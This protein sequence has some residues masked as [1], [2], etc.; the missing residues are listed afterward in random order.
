MSLLLLFPSSGGPAT[1]EGSGAATLPVLTASGTAQRGLKG[2]GSPSLPV[3]TAT[4]TA[5]RGLNASGAATLPV[6]TATGAGKKARSGSGAAT[7]PTLTA[8]GAGKKGRAGTGAATLPILTATGTATRGL[9]GSG[10][11]VLPILTATGDALV[12]G[13][14]LGDGAATLPVITASGEGS[15]TS[16]SGEAERPTGGYAA[17]NYAAIERARR[18]RLKELE[19]EDEADRL[20]A[21]LIAEGQLPPNPVIDDRIAVREYAVQAEAFNRRTQRA[22]DYALRARTD[23][24][25]QLAAREIANQLEDEEYA[26]LLLLAAA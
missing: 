21:L 13:A 14:F 10:T 24:A 23:L 7:L 11:A 26:I 2:S 8:T 1:H 3:L 9:K 4:G 6:L 20:E 12:E 5:K 18:R 16:A 19:D 17:E 25:Y 15:V 22:I